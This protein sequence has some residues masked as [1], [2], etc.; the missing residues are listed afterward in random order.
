MKVQLSTFENNKIPNIL[1]NIFFRSVTLF[2]FQEKPYS[3]AF[4]RW[5]VAK[6]ISATGLTYH[7]VVEILVDLAESVWWALPFTGYNNAYVCDGQSV[8]SGVLRGSS[9]GD[10]DSL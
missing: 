8:L 6:C 3:Y 10:V 4:L 2:C 9:V 5:Q 7:T 1:K